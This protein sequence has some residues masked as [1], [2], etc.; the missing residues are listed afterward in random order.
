MDA[1][2]NISNRQR[3]TTFGNNFYTT[4]HYIYEPDQ[5]Q[6][7]VGF[8][9]LRKNRKISLPQSEMGEKEF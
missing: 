2:L 8:N 1:G 4:T 6:F 5:L 7:S 9:L 3:I